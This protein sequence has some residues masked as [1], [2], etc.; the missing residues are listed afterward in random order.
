ME[1]VLLWI[2]RTVGLVGAGFTLAAFVA[3]VMNIWQPGGI[4]IGTMLQAGTALMV[5]GALAYVA[6]MA[7]RK[8]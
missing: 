1:H 2:G 5:L 4:H 7:E 6:V 8:L 3:R